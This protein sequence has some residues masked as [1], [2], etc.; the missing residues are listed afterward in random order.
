MKHKDIVDAA[1]LIKIAMVNNH[2]KFY[3]GEVVAKFLCVYFA[4][5]YPAFSSDQF[6]KACGLAAIKA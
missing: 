1:T 3:E 5:A 6:L 4:Q 2:L